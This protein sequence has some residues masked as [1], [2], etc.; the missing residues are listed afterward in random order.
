MPALTLSS[1]SPGLG[2]TGKLISTPQ[3]PPVASSPAGTENRVVRERILKINSWA[4]PSPADWLSGAL[5]VSFK[6]AVATA[7][8][9][10]TK[11]DSAGDRS[12]LWILGPAVGEQGLTLHWSP[13]KTCEQQQQKSFFLKA[14][15][16]LPHPPISPI[17]SACAAAHQAFLHQESRARCPRQLWMTRP[18]H[19]ALW[20]SP[21]P[22]PPRLM[23]ANAVIAEGRMAGA[24]DRGRCPGRACTVTVNNP[25]PCPGTQT[26]LHSPI[27]EPRNLISRTAAGEAREPPVRLPQTTL[28]D[29]SA[30]GS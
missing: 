24:W 4:S 14:V 25:L 28:G 22:H 5:W 18:S 2:G 1:P 30:W 15:T 17:T 23:D 29:H 21:G 7:A 27:T 10:G 6:F 20:P 3:I 13:R 8:G 19:D 12:R 9:Q 26:G 16:H 11:G